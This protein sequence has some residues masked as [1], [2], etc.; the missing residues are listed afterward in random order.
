MSSL[1]V[2]IL[3]CPYTF[4]PGQEALPIADDLLL[5]CDLEQQCLGPWFAARIY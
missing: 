2:S 5:G 4:P 1:D 3:H